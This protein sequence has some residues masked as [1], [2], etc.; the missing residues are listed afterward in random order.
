MV[1]TVCVQHISAATN[2]HIQDYIDEMLQVHREDPDLDRFSDEDLRFLLSK[3]AF[4]IRPRVDVLKEDENGVWLFRIVSPRLASAMGGCMGND[5]NFHK[6]TGPNATTQSNA[7]IGICT[8]AVMRSLGGELLKVDD[9]NFRTALP[10]ETPVLVTITL[11]ERGRLTT[12]TIK[13]VIEET[14]K[15]IMKQADLEM[16]PI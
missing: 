5:T 7:L 15:A 2:L 3:Q 14:G 4:G 10:I 8:D 1:T 9:L 16:T 13:I 12:G 6:H 11:K